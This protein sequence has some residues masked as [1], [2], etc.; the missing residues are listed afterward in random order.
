LATDIPALAYHAPTIAANEV[1]LAMM[2]TIANNTVLGNTSGVAAVPSALTSV[3]LASVFLASAAYDS[4]RALVVNGNIR[5]SDQSAIVSAITYTGATAT[6]NRI[7]F[8]AENVTAWTPAVGTDNTLVG[9]WSS[10]RLAATGTTFSSTVIGFTSFPQIV[11]SDAGARLL[12][13]GFQVLGLRNNANDLSSYA[14]NVLYGIQIWSGHWITP[15]AT[16]VTG[17][18]T[19]AIIQ[20]VNYAGTITTASGLSIICSVGTGSGPANPVIGTFY[21][22][23]IQASVFANGGTITNEW[24]IS[25]EST[26]AQNLFAGATTFSVN[27]TF[28]GGLALA[29]LA[30]QA[31]LTILGNISGGVAVPSALTGAP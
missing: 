10:P 30:T 23:R 11:S 5:A 15:P 6:N 20:V 22:I 13:L 2:A 19:A 21:G 16:I 14:S 31:N 8:H 9:F 3:N 7:M 26:T 29:T 28:T 17:V 27:P 1:T 25:Q 24:G 18:A 12:D 4:T